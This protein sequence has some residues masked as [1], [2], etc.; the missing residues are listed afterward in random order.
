P[1][2]NRPCTPAS[3]WKRIN[4]SSDGTSI[5]KSSVNGVHIGG[6]TPPVSREPVILELPSIDRR[7]IGQP[8][9]EFHQNAQPSHPRL[10]LDYAR[11]MH[12]QSAGD[13]ARCYRVR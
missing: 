12:P 4:R 5:S 2:M 8:V 13:A 3:I 9:A 10:P 1:S 6:T 7:E 11:S